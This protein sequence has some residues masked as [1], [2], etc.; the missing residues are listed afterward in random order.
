MKKICI[1]SGLL[2]AYGVMAASVLPEDF[3]FNR[4][5]T[6]YTGKIQPEPKDVKYS[7]KFLKLDNIVIVPPANMPL[8]DLRPRFLRDRIE[9]N[10]GKAK[11]A[12]QVPA[13]CTGIIRLAIGKEAPEH[14]EGY[15]IDFR[16]PNEIV[17]TG[18]DS[19]GVLWGLVS[20]A[21]MVRK[22]EMQIVQVRDYPDIARRGFLSRY[23]P[24][25]AAEFIV[26]NKLNTVVFQMAHYDTAKGR[27][28]AWRYLDQNPIPERT[29][30]MLEYGA[31]AAGLGLDF[32]YSIHIVSSDLKE[33]FRCSSEE[34]YQ[35]LLVNAETL[36]KNHLG[37]Y[38]GMDDSR[39]PAHPDDLKKFGS[40]RQADIYL[41]NR[42]YR[43][44][45]QKYPD[46]RM[47]WCQ[48]FYWGPTSP[49]PYPED[50]TEY[51]AAVGKEVDPEVD[52][53]W[54]GP[55]VKF[56]PPTP[57][58]TKWYADLIQRAPWTFINGKPISHMHF[59]CYVTDPISWWK[60]ETYP[61]FWQDMKAALINTGGPND[62]ASTATFGSYMW[63][64]QNYRPDDCIRLV[65]AMFFGPDS[66]AAL[67]NL[68]KKLSY[69]DKYMW[70]VSAGAAQR[71]PEIREKLKEL[72]TA[73][74]E[75]EKVCKFSLENLSIL[76]YSLAT[77]RKF[78][79]RL[80]SSANLN[81]FADAE[82][83]VRAD[84]EKEAGL[85]KNDL[86]LGPSNFFGGKG[87]AVYGIRGCPRRLA[88]WIHGGQSPFGSMSADFTC[89]P[90]PVEGNFKLI[91]SGQDDDSEI[92]SEIEIKVNDRVIFSGANGFTKLN[93]SKRE[94]TI[95]A[96]CLQR[97]NKLVISSQSPSA[98]I[99]GPPFFMINYA[100]LK[101]EK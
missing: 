8:D 67:D 17:V 59:Y 10:G 74:D 45:K 69:F 54:T 29:V 40:A 20:L 43:E 9:M 33:Q 76:P 16:E 73:Y 26:L 50:R 85:S 86:L 88:N 64:Q 91:I 30:S 48:P 87:P 21:Q 100:V 47:V 62:A 14:S 35:K 18:H 1:L 4:L 72:E 39:F 58:Q 2:F 96:D 66:F 38:L 32:R 28:G 11:I 55:R 94:F 52:I 101:T 98:N 56:D 46:F 89:E 57:E 81:Q 41:V 49:A 24:G 84:A 22:D 53:F 70:K 34:D 65:T 6:Y 97:Q 93:W 95:P 27:S 36:A 83:E 31:V 90:F 80:S 23:W 42:L 78:V 68:N 3:R 71:L 51:L 15:A 5:P 60:T 13:D 77:T 19:Q 82:K 12:H 25:I 44:L 7:G 37:L 79:K 99:T 61:A 92:P 63:N 75:A